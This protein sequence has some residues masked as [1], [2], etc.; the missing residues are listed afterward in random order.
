MKKKK[1][2][3]DKKEKSRL[4]SDEEEEKDLRGEKGGEE[5]VQG[6]ERQLEEAEKEEERVVQ[7]GEKRGEEKEKSEGKKETD[8]YLNT[9]SSE[10]VWFWI[11][12]PPVRLVS[13]QVM[14][15][16]LISTLHS[17]NNSQRLFHSPAKTSSPRQVFLSS[18]RSHTVSPG[19]VEQTLGVLQRLGASH[20]IPSHSTCRARN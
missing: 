10:K 12:V 19:E 17:N 7:G 14:S 18:A 16:R 8:M 6:E 11:G 3:E 4:E 2:E 20:F 9:V 13:S 1:I 5:E 15:S